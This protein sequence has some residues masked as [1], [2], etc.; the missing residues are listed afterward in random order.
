MRIST[1]D[2]ILPLTPPATGK[3]AFHHSNT[4]SS[5]L[6]PTPNA[7]KPNAKAEDADDWRELPLILYHDSRQLSNGHDTRNAGSESSSAQLMRQEHGKHKEEALFFEKSVT[8]YSDDTLVFDDSETDDEVVFV[9]DA[10]SVASSSRNNEKKSSMLKPNHSSNSRHEVLPHHQEVA[11]SNHSFLKRTYM[12]VEDEEEVLFVGRSFKIPR[13]E[14][15]EQSGVIY[16]E[17]TPLQTM[18]HTNDSSCSECGCS[19][20]GNSGISKGKGSGSTTLSAKIRGN[21]TA[22]LLNQDQSLYDQLRSDSRV[23]DWKDIA[24]M[25]GAK[26]EDFD[27]VR[28]AARWL[29]QHLPGLVAKGLP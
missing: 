7:I 8:P 27:R 17:D 14:V 15:A 25:V 6:S 23:R 1:P 11:L 4:P 5:P 29:Q 12:E 24:E 3:K 19:C 2:R 9:G 18:S 22:L 10:L 20:G 13:L 21:I 28:H 26:R 16:R